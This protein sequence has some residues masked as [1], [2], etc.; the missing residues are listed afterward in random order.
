MALYTFVKVVSWMAVPLLVGCQ[1]VGAAAA[2][3][4]TPSDTT[5]HG[6]HEVHIEVDEV[7]AV[8]QGEGAV[9]N[10]QIGNQ[11]GHVQG[12]QRRTVRLG[13]VTRKAIGPKAQACIQ[14]PVEDDASPCQQ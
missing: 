2:R 6:T 7:T 9:A 8:A 4:P 14:I 3:R 13:K 1:D 5:V 12:T 10:V 11:S